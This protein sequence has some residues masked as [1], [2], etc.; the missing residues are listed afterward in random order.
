MD[1]KSCFQIRFCSLSLHPSSKELLLLLVN[2]CKLSKAMNSAVDPAHQRE[3][4]LGYQEVHFGKMWWKCLQLEVSEIFTQK[5][6]QDRPQNFQR[7]NLLVIFE[8]SQCFLR[9]TGEGWRAESEKIVREHKEKIVENILFLLS[10]VNIWI[11]KTSLCILL[12]TN[13]FDLYI[14]IL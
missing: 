2:H 12:L 8:M 1:Q 10:T 14:R 7:L 13:I 6:P 4:I 3:R 11:P 5:R 9:L